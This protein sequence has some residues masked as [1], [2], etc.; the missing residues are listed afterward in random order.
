MIAKVYSSCVIGVDAHEIVA[1]A[2]VAGGLPGF[3]IGGLPDT[4]IRESRDRIKS[5]L[6][7]SGFSF[8]SKRIT[9]NLAPADIK[10]EGASFDLPMALSILALEGMVENPNLENLVFA[11]ELSL[12]GR[13]KP[14]KGALPIAMSLK[15]TSKSNFV[16]PKENAQEA[17]IVK[18]VNVYPAGSL[19]EVVDFVNKRAGIT[20]VSASIEQI[21]RKN[22][23]YKVDFSDVKGQEHV[24][25]GL[26]VAAAGGHNVL[27][28][29]TQYDLRAGRFGR[30]ELCLL[31]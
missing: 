3:S 5:A 24:K 21:F 9:I 17:A 27:I 19:K 7:N 23:K 11:G 4:T 14:I 25:R 29:W 26:E 12:D 13:I 22:S 30:E 16:L 20:A 31:S 8:P 2:D 18:G 15:S 6:K 1:E 10:K 28:L